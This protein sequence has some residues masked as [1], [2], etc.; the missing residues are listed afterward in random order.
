[1]VSSRKFDGS[2]PL[3]NLSQGEKA[4]VTSLEGEAT[5]CTRLREM[6]FCE[7]AIVERISGAHTVLCQ[8][9]G[10]KVALNG[11][12]ARHVIVQPLSSGVGGQG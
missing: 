9:C 12:A 1:M 8:I 2:I 7:A 4:R 5:L 11:R 3:T 10:T 6:G